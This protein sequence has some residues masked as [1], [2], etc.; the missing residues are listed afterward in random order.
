MCKI[1]ITTQVCFDFFFKIV[2]V[3]GVRGIKQQKIAQYKSYICHTQY[4]ISQEQQAYDH[5][6]WYTFV[7]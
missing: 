7:K 4:P 5:H 2:I 6:F 1:M 3:Q